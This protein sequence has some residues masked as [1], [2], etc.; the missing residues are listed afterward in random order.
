[1]TPDESRAGEVPYLIAQAGPLVGH[2][3]QLA[4]SQM[5]IGRG[6]ECDIAI[7]D[8]QISRHHARL[9]R[10][11]EGF[12]V[13]DMGS[14]NG[15]H[16][17]GVKIDG[18]MVLQDGDVIQVAFTLELV[19]VAHDATLPMQGEGFGFMGRLRLD[20]ASHQ[21]WVAG[22]EVAPPLSAPQYRLLE[23]L[24][25]Q[26]GRVVPRDE[27]VAQVWP[28]AAGAGVSEQAIDALVR[29]LRDRLA[30]IDP[31]HQYIVTVRGHGFRLDNLRS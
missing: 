10:T 9:Q 15:T 3:W 7:P 30:E 13:E 26:P 20:A 31:E 23:A 27:V 2:R 12:V 6:P 29:R 14:K 22:Q 18:P 16:V 17:N 8:R 25:R 24:S 11:S 21:V 4:G 5:L 28:D 19:F 1:M